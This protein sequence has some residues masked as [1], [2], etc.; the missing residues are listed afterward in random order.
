MG[1]FKNIYYF[2]EDKWYAVLDKINSKIPVYKLIDPI[3]QVVPSFILFLLL[4]LFVLVLV[5]YVAQFSSNYEVTISMLDSE[6]KDGINGVKIFGKI[7]PSEELFNKVTDSEGKAKVSFAGYNQNLYQLVGDFITGTKFEVD[8]NISA[9]KNGYESLINKKVTL[10]SNEVSLLLSK[11][12]ML[13]APNYKDQEKVELID[14]ST[15]LKIV[16]TT[17]VAYV[18]FNCNNKNVTTQT[19]DDNA[20]GALDGVFTLNKEKCEF[21]VVE[22]AAPG[23]VTDSVSKRIP[24]NQEGNY[25]LS[26]AKS[27]ADNPNGRAKITL[28]EM[29]GTIKKAVVGVK[30]TLSGNGNSTFLPTDASGIADFSILP[31]TYTITIND[32]NFYEVKPTDNYTVT[33]TKGDT[34]TISITL[35]R[36]LPQDQRRVYLKVIDSNSSP[37][38]GA[39]VELILLNRDANNNY[40]GVS[41]SGNTAYNSGSSGLTDSNGLYK[42][43]S[44]S[45]ESD[46]LVVAVIHKDGYLYKA[47]KPNLYK[48]TD[49]PETVF[50]VEAD[51]TNSGSAKVVVQARDGNRALY[52]AKAFVYYDLVIGGTTIKSIQL[53]K[54]GKYTDASGIAWYKDLIAGQEHNYSAKAYFD[55]TNSAMTNTQNFDVNQFTTFRIFMDLNVSYIE[56]ELFDAETGTRI[57]T[58]ATVSVYVAS[59]SSFSQLV[60]TQNLTAYDGVYKSPSSSN[61]AYEKNQRIKI[62]TKVSGYVDNW[63]EKDG[64]ISPLNKGANKFRIRMYPTS[65]ATGDVN[66]FFNDIYNESDDVWAGNS[67][68]LTLQKGQT[69]YAKFDVVAG[70]DLNYSQLLSLSRIIGPIDYNNIL[71]TVTYKDKVDLF[72]C[73]TSSFDSAATHDENYYFPI[74]INGCKTTGASNKQSGIVWKNSILP[75]G[76][77]SFSVKFTVRSSANDSD[78]IGFKYRAKEI[79]G[80]HSNETPLLSIDF[81]LNSPLRAGFIYS[82][83]INNNSIPLTY[84]GSDN[85][86]FVASTIVSVVGESK[87]TAKIKLYNKSSTALSGGTVEVYSYSGSGTID[88]FIPGNAS[89]G[90]GY[91]KFVSLD[92]NK[93]KTLDSSAQVGAYSSKEYSF[94]IYPS[95]YNS[96]DWLVVVSTFGSSTYT[97]F[98]ETK[99]GGR[100]LVLDAEFLAGVENQLFDGRVYEKLNSAAVIQ[101]TNV[102]IN[103]YKDCATT[104]TQVLSNITAELQGNYFYV[105][106]PGVYTYNKDCLEVTALAYSVDSSYAP[107]TKTLY[108]GTGGTP[109]PSLA[110]IDVTPEN[111]YDEIDEVTLDWNKSGKL[112]VRNNCSEPVKV[113]LTTGILCKK[114][115]GA[116]CTVDDSTD[117]INSNGSAT[118]TLTAVNQEYDASATKPNF[119]DLL[120]VF[121]VY[122]KGKYVSAPASK[123]YSIAETVDIHVTN[124]KQCFAISKDIFDY[125]ATSAS[126]IPFTL[127]DEC[128]YTQIGDYFIPKAIVQAFGYNLTSSAPALPSTITFTP[129]IYVTGKTY[130]SVTTYHTIETTWS[131][132]TL[133]PTASKSSLV[134][135][136]NY[137]KYYGL[138]FNLNSVPGPIKKLQF[139]WFDVNNEKSFSTATYGAAIDGNIRINYTDGNV[140]FFTPRAN[141]TLEPLACSVGIN[142]V[143]GEICEIGSEPSIQYNGEEWGAFGLFYIVPPASTK[144]I[145]SIDINIIGNADPTYLE[146]S[147]WPFIDY[148]EPVVSVVESGTD[149]ATQI[150]TSSFSIYPIEGVTYVLKDIRDV[151]EF[152]EAGFTT[153]VNPRAYLQSD[154]NTVLAW[155]EANYLKAKYIGTDVTSFNDKTM[156]LNLVKDFGKGIN[157]GV[158]N[159]TDYVSTNIGGREVSGAQ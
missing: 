21:V 81:D 87:N 72:T 67:S 142:A 97:A 125:T 116:D 33:V 121:P 149:V 62:V 120:G 92:G 14:S 134:S 76:T 85:T 156:E 40:S 144:K 22:A 132:V 135:D 158:I 48:L 7:G 75:K 93:K 1:F 117:S 31:G 55:G 5:G 98:I 20:D 150:P 69:Y 61:T 118:Y 19:V 102:T 59:D 105:R 30:V 143:S 52:K 44:F 136:H 24:I 41:S 29:D 131:N 15:Q 74:D 108:A 106:L 153:K 28:F 71:Y 49:G 18:K 66:I 94:D 54:D 137:K 3:D 148:N 16:D 10:K 84:N 78:K 65:M 46:G 70:K 152:N 124:N 130:T 38:Q 119:T 60:F 146:L 140:Q 51:S 133:A 27:P 86:T 155:I 13:E 115:N 50:I 6:S 39:K 68:A 37:V 32:L 11:R 56:V 147:L 35:R 12:V 45:L 103:V 112:V 43:E 159:I 100:A 111:I 26:L 95:Q 25:K 58:S 101:L 141:F 34:N 126:T 89:M 2:F 90:T 154:T 82:A 99:T 157:Y 96:T 36:L 63:I 139:R 57:S 151:T 104:K 122:V 88:A 23:Y 113:K 123:A 110:C 80:N 107:L 64:S 8:L 145:G 138:N 9:D 77:Y 127:K 129:K 53:E 128:Q 79:D 109:D 47:V 4:L 83:T 17:G 114:A 42:N 91:L 73:D